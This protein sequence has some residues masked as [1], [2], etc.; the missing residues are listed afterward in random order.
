[1]VVLQA[2]AS[3]ADG[4]ALQAAIDGKALHQDRNDGNLVGFVGDRLLAQHQTGGCGEGRNQVQGGLA[5]AAIM[6]APGSLAVDGDKIRPI[7][8]HLANPGGEAGRKQAG[9]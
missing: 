5:A 2:M 4:C 1:M 8:P 6:A 7:R 3:D 9:V